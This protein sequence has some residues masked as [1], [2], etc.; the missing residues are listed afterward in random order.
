MKEASH[1]AR[2]QQ[3]KLSLLTSRASA[4]FPICENWGGEWD[5]NSC[6]ALSV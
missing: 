2:R 4:L 5:L 6:G 3:R 1:Q